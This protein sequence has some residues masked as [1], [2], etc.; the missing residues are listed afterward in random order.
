MVAHFA[1]LGQV[2]PRAD[3]T[4]QSRIRLDVYGI[5]II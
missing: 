5:S 4:G 3:A 2:A 1:G